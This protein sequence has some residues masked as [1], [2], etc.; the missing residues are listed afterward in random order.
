MTFQ[1][2]GPSVKFNPK[3]LIAQSELNALIIYG[4]HI[5]GQNYI[6]NKQQ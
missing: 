3:L 4:G 5:S 2:I 6:G 1:A